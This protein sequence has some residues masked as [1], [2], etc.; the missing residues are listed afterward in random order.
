MMTNRQIS[1][2]A[3]EYY[4]DSWGQGIALHF[5]MVFVYILILASVRVFGLLYE[6]NSPPFNIISTYVPRT[7]MLIVFGAVGT[8]SVMLAYIPSMF[9]MRRYYIGIVS[10]SRLSTTR[11]FFGANLPFINR[12]SITCALTM[13]FLKACTL[14]P[15]LISSYIVYRCAFVSRLEN[16]STAILIL[17]MLALG[18]TLVWAGFWIRYCISLC[19]TRYIVTLSPK[20]NI[21]DACDLSCRL[22]DSN[23]TRFILFWVYNLRYLLPCLLLFPSSVCIPFVK[24]SYTVFVRELMGN[25]WQDKYPLM[26]E[27]WRRRSAAHL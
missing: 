26:I 22:M 10:G 14:L 8:I 24:I 27:R 20:I 1:Q 3:V 19:L 13:F 6:H 25:Y 18:F 2:K 9:M 16:L 15:A 5:Y 17:F 21:F 7:T 23:H 11:Q 4:R 12:I